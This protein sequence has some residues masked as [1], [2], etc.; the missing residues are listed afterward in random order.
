MTNEVKQHLEAA[1]QLFEA[2]AKELERAAAHARRAAEHF[3]DGEVP[4]G[5]AHAWATRG[6]VLAAEKSLDEQALEH[7]LRSRV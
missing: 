7:R 2:A 6:H 5:G 4:R 3:R 1:A